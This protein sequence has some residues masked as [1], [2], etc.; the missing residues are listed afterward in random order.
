[1]AG[2]ATTVWQLDPHTKAKHVILRKYLN[3]WLPKLTKWET[4]VVIIDGFAGPGIYSQGEEGSPVIA[5]KAFLEHAYQ[6]QMKAK[7]KYLFVEEDKKRCASLNQVLASMTIPD[8]VDISIVNEECLT[9]LSDIL[10]YLDEKQSSLAPTFAF[11]DPFGVNVPL[12][13]ISRLMSHPKC[14]VLITFMISA[15]QRFIA[16]PEFE[17]PTDRLYGCKE[18]RHGLQMNGKPREMFLRTLYQ[19]QLQKV[20]G[21]KYVSFFTMKDTKDKPIYD[22]FFATNHASGIDAMKSAMWKVDQSGDYSFSDATDPSQE[23]LFTSE[24]NW[25]QLFD[26]LHAQ[27][28]RTEQPWEVVEEAIRRTPFRILKTPI[29]DEAK[30]PNSRFKIINSS[31]TKTGTLDAKSRIQFP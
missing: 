6:A 18:W 1:M 30:K 23:T 4:R 3:A 26:L 22:L 13:M 7:V 12:D 24:P 5:L 16:T 8:S 19:Q 31:G 11:I 28:A 14:E 21:A 2:Q 15:L 29:K 10:D 27:F 17:G 20:V 25:G 9:A